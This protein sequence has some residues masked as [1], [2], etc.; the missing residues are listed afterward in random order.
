MLHKVDAAFLAD[1]AKRD[2]AA[3]RAERLGPHFAEV[4]ARSPIRAP[5][6]ATFPSSWHVVARLRGALAGS[7][8]LGIRLRPAAGR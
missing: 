6:L 3:R 5:R 4:D 1:A 8:A 2:L 7:L